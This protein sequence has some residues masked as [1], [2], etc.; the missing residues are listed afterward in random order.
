M[1]NEIF[2]KNKNE[3]VNVDSMDKVEGLERS[4]LNSTHMRFENYKV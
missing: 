1:S 3:R 4:I 2:I